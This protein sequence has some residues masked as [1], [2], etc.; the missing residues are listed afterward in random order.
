MIQL[1][2]S[3]LFHVGRCDAL[4]DI[5]KRSVWL[6]H[7]HLVNKFLSLTLFDDIL[8]VSLGDVNDAKILETEYQCY[9]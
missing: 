3:Y 8:N 2:D 5:L 1:I 6:S 4:P 9:R 7:V